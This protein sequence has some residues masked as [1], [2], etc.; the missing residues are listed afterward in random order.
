MLVIKELNLE[1]VEE[2]KGT[3]TLLCIARLN[4]FSVE[5]DMYLGNQEVQSMKTSSPKRL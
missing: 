4:Q 3:E 1:T 2:E 5:N